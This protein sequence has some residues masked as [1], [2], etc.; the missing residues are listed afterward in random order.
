M[1]WALQCPPFELAAIINI[2]PRVAH[3][4]QGC[5]YKALLHLDYKQLLAQQPTTFPYFLCAL[6][7]N[8]PIHTFLIKEYGNAAAIFSKHVQQI[9]ARLAQATLLHEH[10]GYRMNTQVHKYKAHQCR[11]LSQVISH[12]TIYK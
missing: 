6:P 2:H 11:E 10:T 5:F 9:L 7:S 4:V 1:S 3:A 12:H 8:I